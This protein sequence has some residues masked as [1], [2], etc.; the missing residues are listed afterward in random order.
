MN[1]IFGAMYDANKGDSCTITVIATGLED[2]GAKTAAFSTYKPGYITPSSLQG[3]GTHSAGA[4]ATG[5]LNSGGSI[6]PNITPSATP[7]KTI[8]GINK[9]GDIRSSVEEKT[10]KI[11]DFL[12]RK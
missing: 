11:P 6:V 1:I 7:L 5:G 3:K 8:S 2:A 12:Q 9:P 4:M 10:L